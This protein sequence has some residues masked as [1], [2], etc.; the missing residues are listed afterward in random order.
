MYSRKTCI[1]SIFTKKITETVPQK[2][3]TDFYNFRTCIKNSVAIAIKDTYFFK[4]AYFL[5]IFF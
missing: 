2:W 3:H 4:C 1:K 5:H